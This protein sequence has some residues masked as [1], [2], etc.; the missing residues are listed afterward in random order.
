MGSACRARMEAGETGR[1]VFG[2]AVYIADAGVAA[3]VVGVAPVHRRD[4]RPDSFA[5]ATVA[6]LVRPSIRPRGGKYLLGA[7]F[8]GAAG[9]VAT[10]DR[11]RDRTA[12]ASASTTECR[13]SD[14]GGDREVH[15]PHDQVEKEETIETRL[16]LLSMVIHYLHSNGQVVIFL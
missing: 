3:A 5:I 7:E 12:R 15:H 4:P 14:Q 9:T 11:L 13:G 8:G 2:A 16:L 1:G 10:G 6:R